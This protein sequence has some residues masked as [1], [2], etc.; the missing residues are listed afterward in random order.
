MRGWIAAFLVLCGVSVSWAQDDALV[1][2]MILVGPTDDGGWSQRHYEAGQYVEATLGA[3]MLVE[4]LDT[5]E[6]SEENMRDVVA[7]FIDGGASVIFTT[8]ADFQDDTNDVAI[9]FGDVTFIHISGDA[10]IRGDAPDNLGNLM[11][12]MEWGKFV[13]GCAAGLVTQTGQ[14]GYLGAFSNS[15]TRRL[16]S[17]AYLGARHCYVT[18][19]DGDPEDLEFELIWLGY[20][21][22]RE[23]TLDAAFEINRLYNNGADVVLSGIDTP[24]VLDVAETR[25]QEGERVYAGVYNSVE[26]CT[27]SEVCLGVPFF[28]WG[29]TY[30]EIVQAVEGDEWS[31]SWT[32]LAPSWPDMNEAD[33]IVQY[34]PGPALTPQQNR[35]LQ[36]FI[37]ELGA[38]ASNAFTP[39]SFALWEGP[40]S[41]ENG[42]VIA[43]DGQFVDILTVWYLDG[44]LEGMADVTPEQPSS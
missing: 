39:E 23:D 22:E 42:R 36:A 41:L 12:Q 37:N 16:A 2:G 4:T 10:V 17:S 32:W 9:E 40:L 5:S 15:E 43:E 1:F 24:V 11:G 44:L 8:S 35:Q 34:Q 30:V 27:G 19:Q 33:S 29:P 21:Y 6:T 25:L 7:G 31:T 38:Y 13:D 28:H 20:W 26:R 14:I 3:E 18:Y